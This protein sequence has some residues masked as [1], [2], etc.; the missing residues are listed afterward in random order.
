MTTSTHTVWRVL[1]N[2]K[3]WDQKKF[4]TNFHVTAGDVR[5]AQSKGGRKMVTL[6][7]IGDTVFFVIKGK[8]VM[9]GVME[10]DGFITGTEHQTDP[11]NTGVHRF[12]A[13]TTEFAWVRVTD[14]GM[15]EPIKWVGQRTW[16]KVSVTI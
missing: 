9:R 8:I 14:V 3:L 11:C 2:D 12:H 7:H 5:I 6:P 10:S 16:A 1:L 13:E 15:A 4:E